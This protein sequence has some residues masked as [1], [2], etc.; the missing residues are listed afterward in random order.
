MPGFGT[1]VIK[2]QGISAELIIANKEAVNGGDKGN[3]YQSQDLNP[4]TLATR[5]MHLNT[6]QTTFG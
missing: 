5:S 4:G 2:C 3:K 1:N 6:V